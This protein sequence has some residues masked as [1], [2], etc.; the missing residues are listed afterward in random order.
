[1]QSPRAKTLFVLGG[2]RPP[3]MQTELVVPHGYKVLGLQLEVCSRRWRTE[4]TEQ[5][6]GLLG[7][8]G[9]PVSRGLGLRDLVVSCGNR[10]P[11]FHT[12]L[13]DREW[14]PHDC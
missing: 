10:P 14:R 2:S 6:L 12:E 8:P 1:M 3:E 9:N 4:V 7:L 13:W 11:G 5:T